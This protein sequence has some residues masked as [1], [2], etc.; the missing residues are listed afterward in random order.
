MAFWEHVDLT[1]ATALAERIIREDTE[2]TANQKKKWLLAQPRHTHM[3]RIPLTGQVGRQEQGWLLREVP[4]P[5]A[6]SVPA[7]AFT[8]AGVCTDPEK[9]AET[10]V[11][12]A[13]SE[14]G[15]GVTGSPQVRALQDPVI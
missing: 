3:E 13:E 1:E 5:T 10:G 15:Q 12:L 4:E 11:L 9:A 8:A 14:Q 6:D 7:T 2:T